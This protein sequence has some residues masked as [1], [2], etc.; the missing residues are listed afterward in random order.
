MV[1][2]PVFELTQTHE[3][4]VTEKY[5]IWNFSAFWLIH[6][7]TKD[8]GKAFVFW[9]MLKYQS[10]NNDNSNNN[11]NNNNNNN[12]NNNNININNNSSNDNNNNNNN[13]KNNNKN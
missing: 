4:V 12:I 8:L 2:I 7:C 11:N 1:L 3:I 6:I 5:K 13:N 10:N 9:K